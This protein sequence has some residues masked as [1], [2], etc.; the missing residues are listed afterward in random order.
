M[1]KEEYIRQLYLIT[2]GIRKDKEEYKKKWS[3]VPPYGTPENDQWYL[4]VLGLIHKYPDMEL[5]FLYKGEEAEEI[6]FR[7]SIWIDPVERFQKGFSKFEGEERKELETKLRRHFA[8]MAFENVKLAIPIYPDTSKEDIDDIWERVE[9]LKRKY[10][11]AEKRPKKSKWEEN[12]RLYKFGQERE[13]VA[14]FSISPM[15]WKNIA[16]QLGISWQT[17]RERYKEIKNL[18]ALTPSQSLNNEPSSKEIDCESCIYKKDC[19]LLKSNG[20]SGSCRVFDE[21]ENMQ[22]E[23]PIQSSISIEQWQDDTERLLKKIPHHD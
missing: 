3:A 23:L 9:R 13:F 20:Q 6:V 18:L 22:P 10:Y 2:K 19:V 4:D 14:D 16:R 7:K 8:G 11:G 21:N 12:L 1:K 17:C 5:G 15:P